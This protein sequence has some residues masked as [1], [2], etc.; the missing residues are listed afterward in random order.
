MQSAIDA[1]TRHESTFAK[2]MQQYDTAIGH[3][4]GV[5]SSV[6]N[7]LTRHEPTFTKA[8]RQYDHRLGQ[9]TGARAAIEALTADWQASGPG[10]FALGYLGGGRG[11][12]TDLLGM[13]DYGSS[14]AELMRDTQH[15]V[16]EFMRQRSLMPGPAPWMRDLHIPAESIA[17]MLRSWWPAA[18]RGFYAARVALRAALKVVR[19]LTTNDPGAR[20]AV[21][22][23]VVDWLGFRR[24]SHDLVTSATLVLLNVPLWLPTG[25]VPLDFDPR[26]KLR[27]LTLAEHRAVTRLSTDPKLR[28]QKQPL[29]SLEQPVKLTDSDTTPTSLRELLP[30]WAAPDPSAVAE[31]EFSDPRIARVWRRLNPREREILR[32]KAQPRVTWASAAVEC[33]GPPNEGEKL[34]RKVNRLAKTDSGPQSPIAE[35]G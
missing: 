11:A 25:A 15:S 17:E 26:P 21:Q 9:L 32:V 27:K 18:D 10:R 20:D 35:A 4:Y 13:Q 2:A 24:S 12:F 7:A 28:F 34:R 30:D 8:L 16:H 3:L 14:M 1:L 5:Q 29:L 6:M 33:G 23:F 19:L 31:R 22:Q